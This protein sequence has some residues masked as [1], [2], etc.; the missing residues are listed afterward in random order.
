MTIIRVF[1]I[2]LLFLFTRPLLHSAPLTLPALY[3][4]WQ[5]M[6]RGNYG[7]MFHFQKN[8]RALCVIYIHTRAVV[9]KGVYTLEDSG[10]IR[11]NIS[12]MKTEDNL[13]RLNLRSRFVKTSSSYF[14]FDGSCDS[15]P[16]ST[17]LEL[18]PKKIIIDGNNSEG[19]FEPLIK[20]K[21]I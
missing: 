6:Y 19:Y 18:T 11:I 3:G 20:L 15:S 7:Y 8:Y 5:L 4:K 1:L 9:F 10:T 2:A 21:R 16:G 13:S 12:E 17:Q 14:V